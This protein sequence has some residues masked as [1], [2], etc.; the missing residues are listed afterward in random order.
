MPNPFSAIGLQ[1]FLADP[2]DLGG[3]QR[4]FAA[5]VLDTKSS[6]L[7]VDSDNNNAGWVSVADIDGRCAAG[8]VAELSLIHI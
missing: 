1:N 8:R 7:L 4:A 5:A 2:S 6:A 3:L